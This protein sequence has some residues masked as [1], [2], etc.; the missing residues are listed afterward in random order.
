MKNPLLFISLLIFSFSVQAQ[1]PQ[2]KQNPILS[3][4][5]KH[6]SEQLQQISQK[7][8][9]IEYRISAAASEFF[10]SG[11]WYKSD[12]I[13]LRYSGERP[14]DLFGEILY[15]E[16]EVMNWNGSGYSKNVILKQEYNSNDDP[17]SNTLQQW[18]GTAYQNMSRTVYTYNA[19][20][21]I[22]T[23]LNQE[24]ISNAWKDDNRTIYSYDGS[25]NLISQHYQY[26]TTTWENDS[27]DSFIYN[28]SGQQIEQINSL[29][30]S[31]W[32]P[33]Y[34]LLQ[35][36]NPNGDVTMVDY[37]IHNGSAWENT[38]RLVNVYSANLVQ[39]TTFSEWDGSAYQDYQRIL[40]TYHI[41]D[42]YSVVTIQDWNGNWVDLVKEEYAYDL[43]NNPILYSYFEMGST[44]WEPSVRQKIYYETFITSVID[45]SEAIS[46]SARPNPFSENVEIIL[47]E[48]FSYERFNVYDITGKVIY[49]AKMDS[50]QKIIWNGE[51]QQG[52]KVEQGIYI[53]EIITAEKSYTGKLM[54][55]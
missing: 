50:D 9:T 29:W 1:F 48:D 35:T 25:G 42:K 43:N 4:L 32:E 10:Q 37:Q 44:S 36:Y 30:N 19:A 53:Y 14:G 26:Y 40:Y 39:T 55:L 2:A 11:A 38:E 7:T 52:Q 16:F 12:S 3:K 18:D 41:D 51:N 24:W 54:K 23:E 27:R 34:R 5:Q 20:G 31:G 17:I 47:P 33:Y 49:T 8:A 15:D 13:L 6:K 21:D 22:T 28:A 46:V 45:L